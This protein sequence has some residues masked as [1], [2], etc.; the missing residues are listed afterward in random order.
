M[1]TT[2]VKSDDIHDTHRIV[3]FRKTDYDLGVD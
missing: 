1:I 2:N 3:F